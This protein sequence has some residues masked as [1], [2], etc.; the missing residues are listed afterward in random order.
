M[1]TKIIIKDREGNEITLGMEDKFEV[2]Y[3]LESP[4]AIYDLRF[5]GALVSNM[6]Y[7]GCN[8]EL[9][10]KADCREDKLVG[11]NEN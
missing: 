10:M 4:T 5:T 3:R 2:I 11:K 8:V 9:H 6:N 1:E 7:S